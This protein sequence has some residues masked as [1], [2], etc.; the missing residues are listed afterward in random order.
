[1][2]LD[3]AGVGEAVV[4][5]IAADDVV[6]D[7][8]AEGG[9]GLNEPDHAVAI[10]PAWGG[11]SG[12]V[13]VQADDGG[14][15]G[16]DGWI[17]NPTG[18]NYRSA[19]APLTHQVHPDQVVLSIEYQDLEGF[20]VRILSGDGLAPDTGFHFNPPADPPSSRSEVICCNWSACRR[21]ST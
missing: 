8:D 15:V 2:L 21:F 14:A 19:E 13:I 20:A 3:K 1:M 12:R 4:I 9:A 11:I 5:C 16:H 17:E 6:E 10:I 7:A 18:M